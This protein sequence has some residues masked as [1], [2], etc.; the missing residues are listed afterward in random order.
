MQNVNVY[1]RQL[2]QGFVVLLFSFSFNIHL[3]YHSIN[4]DFHNF[5]FYTVTLMLENPDVCSR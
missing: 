1:I 2:K 3:I 4:F 5:S